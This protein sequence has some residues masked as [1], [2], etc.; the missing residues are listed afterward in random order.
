MT[1]HP[2]P[3]RISLGAGAWLEYDPID[4]G[5]EYETPRGITRIPIEDAARLG[6]ALIEM[7]RAVRGS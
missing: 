4:G 5:L 2:S 7:S 6:R 3:S 1:D